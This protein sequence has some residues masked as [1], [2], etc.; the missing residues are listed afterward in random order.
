MPDLTDGGIARLV[1]IDASCK[2][3][4]MELPSRV[5]WWT[6]VLPAVGLVSCHRDLVTHL[7]DL[8]NHIPCYHTCMNYMHVLAIRIVATGSILMT[9][10]ACG[11]DSVSVAPVQTAEAPVKLADA[12]ACNSMGRNAPFNAD[13][14]NTNLSG[15]DLHNAFLAD[16]NLRGINLTRANLRDAKLGQSDL[17]GATLMGADLTGAELIL[18]NFSGANLGGANLFRV[19]LAGANLSKSNLTNANLSGAIMIRVDLS[20]ANLSGANLSGANLS[21]VNLDAANLSGANLTGAILP[22]VSLHQAA[23]LT[24]ANLARVNIGRMC[25]GITRA[26]LKGVTDLDTIKGLVDPAAVEQVD[27]GLFVSCR[28]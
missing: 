7:P 1:T 28:S 18:A 27:Q 17:R 9:A 4:P 26:D 3:V 12:S 20:G 8:P 2:M 15:C 21:E 14:S 23:K 10:M 19:N 5:R 16:A 24:N 25:P 13:L 6:S 11:S 22:G